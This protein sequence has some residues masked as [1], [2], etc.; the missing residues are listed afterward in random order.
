MQLLYGLRVDSARLL[1]GV[2]DASPAG[3]PDVV[4]DFPDAPL[5]EVTG[6]PVR[7]ASSGGEGD[8]ALT[9][10]DLAPRRTA[11]RYGD[12][13]AVDLHL[14]EPVARISARIAPGQTLD[15]FAAYLYGP[16]FGHLLRQRGVLALHASS[17]SIDDAAV[18]FVGDQGA[19]KSTTA[20]ALALRGFPA[21]S[22]DLTALGHTGGRWH[23]QPAFDFLRLWPSS[24]PMLYGR[25]GVLHPFSTTWDKRCLPLGAAGFAAIALPVRAIYLLGARAE[26]PAPRVATVAA[27]DALVALAGESYANYLLD[28]GGRATELA[29]LGSLVREVPVFRLVPHAAPSAL[30]ALCDLIVEHARAVGRTGVA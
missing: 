1:P 29:Q 21:L 3:A 6:A 26:E 14:S 7:Y 11:F 8:S 23:A 19:G 9:V 15:D 10:H 13:T 5:A 27:R 28:A 18:L 24:E 16:V 30:P 12:G 22:D 4:I 25:S 17:V 20:A 2:Q